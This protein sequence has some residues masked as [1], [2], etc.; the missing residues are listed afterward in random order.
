M[1]G[2]RRG[3]VLGVAFVA[4]TTLGACRPV[5]DAAVTILAAASLRDAVERATEAYASDRPA[6]RFVVATDSS[7]ALR[8]QIEQGA[9]ADLF[10]SADA[11]NPARLVDAGLTDGAPVAFA[12]ARLVVVVPAGNPAAI[13]SPRDLARDGVRI[14]AAGPE[15][16]ITAYADRLVAALA[17]L[18]G[19]PANF[20]ARYARNV[21]SRE[22]N[23]RAVIAKI[24][25]GEGDAA[26]VYEPDAGASAGVKTVEVPDAASVAATYSG[27]VVLGGGSTGEAHAFLDW[28][29]GPD[30]QA[31]LDD[32]GFGPAA[33]LAP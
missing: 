9:P 23:A 2:G 4:A 15:V 19:Y 33:V 10:L 25:L 17:E 31:I 7:A 30:G 14:I 3:L 29:V 32:L 5:D 21:R 24:A 22:D 18:D 13:E 12:S 6:A 27:V 8:A 20:A 1:I 28:L 16:P 26:I 11:V